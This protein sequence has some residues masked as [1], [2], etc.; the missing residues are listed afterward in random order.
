MNKPYFEILRPG[1]NTTIQDKGRNNL[2]HIGIAVSGAI[3]QRNYKLANNLVENKNNEPVIEFAYQGPHL[4]LKH[5]K[6]NFSITGDIYFKIIRSN[7]VTE[8]G[9]CYKNYILENDDQVDIIS[10][11]NSAYG[12][13]SVGGGF[14]IKKI[15]SSYSINTK[16]QIGPNNGKKYSL[17]QKI[18]IN[19]LDFKEIKKRKI[20]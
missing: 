2:Y 15:W 8:E 19:N 13:L 5:G 7:F 20:Q 16:A 12:Y 1:I 18:F 14:D 4:R 17:N 9:E 6:I 11:K 10:T 3:D